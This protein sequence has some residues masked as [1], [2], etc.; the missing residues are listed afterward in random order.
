MRKDVDPRV[1]GPKA[2][3]FLE[4]CAEAIDEESENQYKHLIELLP[5]VL[6]CGECRYHT[7]KYL[8]EHPLDTKNLKTW[9]KAFRAAVSSRKQSGAPAC[10]CSAGKTYGQSLG[11]A[12]FLWV[13]VLVVAVLALVLLL[14]PSARPSCPSLR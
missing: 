5:E 10:G 9:L 12:S 4:Y 13:A 8:Q 1:W 11:G 14:C 2:W 6:P 7:R 3:D